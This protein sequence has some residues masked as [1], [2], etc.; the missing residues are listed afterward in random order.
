[1]HLLEYEAKQLLK[2]S[3]IPVPKS[4]VSA[5]DFLPVVIKSQV[6]VGGR[7][8]AGGIVIAKTKSERNT[9][10]DRLK[11][12]SIS[13]HLPN[14]LLFEEVLDIQ[15]EVY[16]S[17]L[18]NRELA[19]IE[20]LAHKNGGVEVESMDG[21]FNKAIRP[22]NFDI[23]VEQLSR[24]LELPVDPLYQ[25]VK[26]LYDCFV[27]NDCLLLEIN[28]LVVTTSGELVAADCKM[29]ID[30]AALFRHTNLQ[31]EAKTNDS[32]FVTLNKNGSVATL[33][34]GAGLAMATVDAVYAAGYL[35]ANFLDIGGGVTPESMAD[36]FQNIVQ[37]SSVDTIVINIFGGIVRCDSVAEAII[38]ALAT[39]ENLPRLYI[40][41]SG[42]NQDEAAQ[43]LAAHAIVLYNSLD[44]ILRSLS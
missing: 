34:N 8:K 41:L 35:P 44:D 40:R 9:A 30:D 32:N 24:H 16:V 18:I 39:F 33:A 25:L 1:M 37:F 38:A 21:F 17:I 4:T 22:A 11:N 26:N 27:K 20:L 7:G 6:P 28:P 3:S 23:V 29:E 43:L 10:T 13:G 42:T 15:R 2:S 36:H 5:P 12:L 31:F 19:C 14:T